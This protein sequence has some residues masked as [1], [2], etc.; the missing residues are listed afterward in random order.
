MTPG[1]ASSPQLT[2]YPAAVGVV[3]GVLLT[4]CFAVHI[5]AI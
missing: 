4:A 2:D 1:D 5:G 3:L